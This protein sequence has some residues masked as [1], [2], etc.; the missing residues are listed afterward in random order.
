MTEEMD[1]WRMGVYLW[2]GL[3]LIN[4]PRGAIHGMEIPIHSPFTGHEEKVEGNKS[5][6]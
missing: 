1:M 6:G 3:D 4:N 5:I 2:I